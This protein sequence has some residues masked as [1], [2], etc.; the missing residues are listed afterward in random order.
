M[1]MQ[2]LKD[3]FNGV[4]HKADNKVLGKTKRINYVP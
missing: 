4:H 1:I 3:P 2:L